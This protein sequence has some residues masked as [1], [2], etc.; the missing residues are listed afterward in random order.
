MF[1]VALDKGGDSGV[2][3]LPKDS[4]YNWNEGEATCVAESLEDASDHAWVAEVQY[5]PDEGKTWRRW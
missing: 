3:Y 5:S 2:Q 4:E 1:R